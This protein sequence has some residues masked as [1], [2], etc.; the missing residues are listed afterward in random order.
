MIWNF[1]CILFL[2][3]S[4]IE[5]QSVIEAERRFCKERNKEIVEELMKNTPKEALDS[6]EFK[7]S[8][9]FVYNIFT[10]QNQSILNFC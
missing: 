8:L 6:L 2:D 4:F 9:T 10:V 3:K 7:V 1:T 5:K